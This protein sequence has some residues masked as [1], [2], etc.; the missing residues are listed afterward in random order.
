MDIKIG[1][2][3]R[4]LNDVGGGKVASILPDN[5]IMVIDDSGFEIP[6]FRKELVVVDTENSQS[7][8]VTIS[9]KNEVE[10]PVNYH[11]ELIF[12]PQGTILSGNNTPKAY[13]AIVPQKEQISK[14]DLLNVHIVNDCNYHLFVSVYESN[15]L[16]NKFINTQIIAPNKNSFIYSIDK[17]KYS[18]DTIEITVNLNFYSKNSVPL[19]KPWQAKIEIETSV[20]TNSL[21]FKK[22]SFFDTPS[23]MYRLVDTDSNTAEFKKAIET[24]TKENSV[25]V[26]DKILL[27]TAPSE[28]TK[29]EKPKE[30]FLKEVDL[31]IQ[32]LVENTAGLTPKEMLDIQMR[33]FRIEFDNALSEKFKRVVFIHGLGNG[34]L[35]NE[36]RRT[37]DREYKKYEYHDASF[38]EYGFGA[39]MVI[40]S[41]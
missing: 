34:T 37:L 14:S 36:I 32:S 30:N 11:N 12:F 38:K 18:Y 7:K 8:D 25:V 23:I 26:A 31:H 13:V 16:T 4:Y 5:R 9:T 27:D 15:K 29:K 33:Q 20:F 2:T 39:T 10:I 41:K 40:L 19:I 35:K 24:L 1:D 21:M 6:M 22:N 28:N 17:N 3:V